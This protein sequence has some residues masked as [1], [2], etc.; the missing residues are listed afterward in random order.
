ME[1]IDDGERRYRVLLL[2]IGDNTEEKRDSFARKFPKST[3]SLFPF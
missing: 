3:A 1:R 2:G